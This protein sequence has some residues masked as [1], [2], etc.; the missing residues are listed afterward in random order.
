M[1][2]GDA[3]KPA[4]SPKAQYQM[5]HTLINEAVDERAFHLWLK[6]MWNNVFMFRGAWAQDFDRAYEVFSPHDFGARVWA[7]LCDVKVPLTDENGDYLPGGEDDLQPYCNLEYERFNYV[8]VDTAVV[9]QDN[10]A[11]QYEHDRYTR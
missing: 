3:A 7:D 11:D 5:V 1:D 10:D 9:P 4:V 8:P 6:D 2:V